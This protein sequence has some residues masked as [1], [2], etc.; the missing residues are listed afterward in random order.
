MEFLCDD[1]L[2]QRMLR[3]HCLQTFCIT[4]SQVLLTGLEIMAKE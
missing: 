1:F 4:I 3:R 2:E